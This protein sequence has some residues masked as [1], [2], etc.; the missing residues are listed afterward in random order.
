M[1]TNNPSY[2]LH[3]DPSSSVE[4]TIYAANPSNSGD[5]AAV[6]GELTDPDAGGTGV[7]GEGPYSGVEGEATTPGGVGV[8]GFATNE[9]GVGVF[10][11]GASVGVT[12]RAAVDEFGSIGVFGEGGVYGVRGTSSVQDGAGVYGKLFGVGSAF[13]YGVF[14]EITGTESG[15]YGVYGKAPSYGVVGEVTVGGLAVSG[16]APDG[17]GIYGLS[18]S[19]S[20]GSAGVV[21]VND[22]TT[23]TTIGVHG[24][25]HSNSGY[26]GYFEGG[27]NYFEG[28]VGCGTES[29]SNPLSVV[30]DADISGQV[31]IGITGADARL[32]VRGV[33]GEDA[34]RVRVDTATKLVVKDNGGVAIGA[35]YSDV[36]NN[37]LR[38]S[39][40]VAIN[41]APSSFQLVCNGSAAKPGGGSWSTYSDAR[42][43]HSIEP[44]EPGTL[45]RLL[46]L[47]GYTFE[48][49]DEAVRDKLGLPGRQ[50]GLIAQEVQEVFPEWVETDDEGYLYVTERGLTAI[51]VE[52]VRELRAEKATAIEGLREQ[53]RATVAEIETLR[54]D[55]AALQ[56]DMN[57]LHERLAR[58]EAREQKSTGTD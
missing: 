31:S 48:H 51:V 45:D 26:A 15:G 54:A 22:L 19:D 52:A 10:G 17:I 27:R 42:L 5:A 30:G 24:V 36:P 12:G 53:L 2:P 39:G 56:A 18:S 32:L 4:R 40:N 58:L 16:F 44:M 11:S 57:A 1:G 3:V 28:R 41:A 33:A 47:Q 8:S 34:F 13:G 9:A 43:K 49:T 25:V 29:P 14:G 21:G 37:G 20:A 7:R 6:F 50:T 55:N 46:S 38:V 23:G 35:N